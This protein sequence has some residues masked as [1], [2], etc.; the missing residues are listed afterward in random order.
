MSK[1]QTIALIETLKE[2]GLTLALAESCTGGI[3]GALIT[4]IPDVSA[5]YMGGII[6]YRNEVK[7]K[8]LKVTEETLKQY[9]AVSSKTAQE[10]AIGVKDALGSDIGASITGIAGPG[11]GTEDKP[12][13]TVYIAITDGKRDVSMKLPLEHDKEQ[14][15]NT[16]RNDSAKMLIEAIRNFIR[17]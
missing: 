2:K 5:C 7:I 3:T 14:T 4:E 1:D 6:A 17:E 10:M 15:R 11:G 12:I 13:G 8:L 9:G 16:I